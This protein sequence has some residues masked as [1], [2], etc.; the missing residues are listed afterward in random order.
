MYY[1]YLLKCSD[2]TIYA[3]YTDDLEKRLCAHN[4]GTGAK[5]TRSRLPVSLA[6]YERFDSKSEAMRRESAFKHLTRTEKI[7]LIKAFEAG[8]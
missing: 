5:Y 2:G 4:A 1:A 6:Y 8:N 3:G 7:S